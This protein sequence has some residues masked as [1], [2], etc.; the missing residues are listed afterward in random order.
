MIELHSATCH[1]RLHNATCHPT[2]V[3][4]SLNPATKADTLF[5]YSEGMEG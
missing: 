5:T 3:N 2:Q 1:T 4:A